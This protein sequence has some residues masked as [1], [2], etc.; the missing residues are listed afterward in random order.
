MTSL[1]LLRNVGLNVH[2]S[3]FRRRYHTTWI[4]IYWLFIPSSLLLN[5]QHGSWS[6]H[7]RYHY[8]A[9]KSYWLR[10]RRRHRSIHT[11]YKFVLIASSSS[12]SHDIGLFISSLLSLPYDIGLSIT[13][14]L[15]LPYNTEFFIIPLSLSSYD[16]ELFITLPSLLP[17]NSKYISIHHRIIVIA[18]PAWHRIIIILLSSLRERHRIIE[19]CCHRYLNDIVLLNVVV[20]VVAWTTSNC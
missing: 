15:S 17:Y 19:S 11:T 10:H 6:L 18:K 8:R 1:L 20:V 7:C 14:L 12:L 3:S 9:V 4:C 16:T 2:Y 13:S 5:L